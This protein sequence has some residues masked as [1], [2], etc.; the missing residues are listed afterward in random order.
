MTPNPNIRAKRSGRKPKNQPLAPWQYRDYIN[1]PAW[2]ATRARYFKSNMPKTCQGCGTEDNILDLHHR[3]YGTL[4][5]E[6]LL[7]L[8]LLCHICHAKVHEIASRKK[9]K[10][11]IWDATRKITR[12]LLFEKRNKKKKLHK[13]KKQTLPSLTWPPSTGRALNSPWPQQ[14]ISTNDVS[15]N[16]STQSVK[17]V[18][19]HRSG[20]I[21]NGTPVLEL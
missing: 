13:P 15:P 2:Q 14:T 7:D 5:K 1:S 6:N 8:V 19:C 12:K 9:G 4:G 10:N 3:S 18:S 16:L 21:A 11:K 17:L 20:S